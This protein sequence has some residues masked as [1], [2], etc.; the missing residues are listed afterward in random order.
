MYVDSYRGGLTIK[1]GAVKYWILAG[2]ILA[3][4]L[5]G[6][7]DLLEE[8]KK[9]K[10]KSLSIAGSW[11]GIANETSAG[12]GKGTAL[13]TLTQDGQDIAGTWQFKF[14]VGNIAGTAG[15]VLTDGSS[16]TM[17]LNP[18][19]ASLCSFG[20]TAIATSTKIDGTFSGIGCVGTI[21]GTL[22]LNK[23]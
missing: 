6:C 20:V 2:I 4:V 8:D 7:G 13:A 17:V 16:L 18:S 12:L 5:A 21:F 11:K 3:T 15:G 23:Q 1:E 14:S 22:V 19:D 10:D 9:K